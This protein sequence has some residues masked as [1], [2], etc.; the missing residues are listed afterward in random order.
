MLYVNNVFVMSVFRLRPLQ[1]YR[2]KYLRARK[3][4]SHAY[5]RNNRNDGHNVARNIK[6]NVAYKY[7]HNVASN[8]IISFNN[9]NYFNRGS[10]QTP[11]Y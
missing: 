6:H 11:K 3:H 4:S 7:A 8:I 10:A 9:L 2:C 5:G 1:V